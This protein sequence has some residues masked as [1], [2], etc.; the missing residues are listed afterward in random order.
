MSSPIIISHFVK[1]DINNLFKWRNDT[2]TR[3]M[4]HFQETVGWNEH[5]KWCQDVLANKNKLLLLCSFKEK[6]KKI[7]VVR[8]D[9]KGTSTNVSINLAPQIRGQGLAKPCLSACIDYFYSKCNFVQIL[10]AEIKV[11]NIPSQ[12]IFESLG[13]VIKNKTN[14]LKYYELIKVE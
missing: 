4:S 1:E 12:K 2:L 13:F 6:N 9:I 11:D 5:L 8:V 10:K 14:S 7:A 3:Q